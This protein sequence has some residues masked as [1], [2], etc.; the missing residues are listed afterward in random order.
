MANLSGVTLNINAEKT[1]VIFPN[2]AT[3]KRPVGPSVEHMFGGSEKYML[4]SCQH[5]ADGKITRKELVNS[6]VAF[7][8]HDGN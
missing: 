4:T 2:V 7:L 5:Y 8:E 6:L 3:S 1:F